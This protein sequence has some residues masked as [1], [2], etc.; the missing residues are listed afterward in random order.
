MSSPLPV[1]ASERVFG[2]GPGATVLVLAPHPDDET[3][4]AG[5]T[6]ARLTAAGAAVH[7]LAVACPDGSMWGGHSD[8]AVRVK[9]FQAACDILGVAER[10][11]ACTGDGHDGRHLNARE[12]LGLVETGPLGTSR[13]RPDLLLIPAACGFHQ[14]HL[15]VHQVGMAACR[16]GGTTKPTPR[17]V[18]GYTGPDECWTTVAEPHRV[19]VDTTDAWPVKQRAIEAYGSQLRPSP[20]PR[21]VEAIRTLD[22]A[23]GVHISTGM[24][25]SLVAY[26]MAC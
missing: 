11:V 18:L 13:L 22:A 26:R 4:G 16:L 19:Y 5:G 25:E 10:T 12:L 9:E 14:D 1:A 2:Y 15:A 24:A 8:P 7:V 6:I 3:L 17:M 23:A 20:H 21:S